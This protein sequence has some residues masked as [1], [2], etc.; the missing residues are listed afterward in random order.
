MTKA[1]EEKKLLI[2]QRAEMIRQKLYDE[3]TKEQFE[4]RLTEL[5]ETIDNLNYRKN[6]GFETARARTLSFYKFLELREN[7]VQYWN[8]LDYEKKAI[9]SKI[10]ISN[11]TLQWQEVAN[12]SFKKPFSDDEKGG[13]TSNGTRCEAQLEPMLEDL[14]QWLQGSQNAPVVEEILLM[15]DTCKPSEAL[16]FP[17]IN[18]LAK[19][20][21]TRV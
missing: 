16:R 13:F 20:S 11:L 19:I 15:A 10:V 6:S 14:R 5:A 21:G 2:D 17:L 12:L 8:F 9:F 1:K 18:D 4:T 7:L 3:Q